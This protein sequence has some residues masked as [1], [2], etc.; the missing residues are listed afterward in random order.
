MR[1]ALLAF[2]I[3]RDILGEAITEIELPENPS[4]RQLRDY[5]NEQ[6]PALT[7]LNSLMI[8]VNEEYAAD[9]D[10]IP[11]NAE[12]ALIPPVSGG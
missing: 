4:V 2:G 6:Y 10:Q 8:A 5:L 3:C 7:N 9:E 1:L 11:E 12:I